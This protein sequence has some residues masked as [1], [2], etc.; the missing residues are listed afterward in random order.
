VASTVLAR[1]R[2]LGNDFWVLPGAIALAF[3]LLAQAFVAIDRRL[4]EGAFRF[5]FDGDA[6]AARGVL[7]TVAGSVITVAGLTFSLTIVVLS[8]VSGQ[9]TPR[10]VPT[11]L[12]DRVTQATA[13]TFI[14][15]FTYCLLVLRSVRDPADGGVSGFVPE[16]SVTTAVGLAVL[17]IALL[18]YF[19]HH[20]GVSIQASSIVNR[21]GRQTLERIREL[22]EEEVE[23]PDEPEGEPG[24]VRAAEPGYV[25][26]VELAALADGLDGCEHVRLRVVPGDFVTGADPL[27]HVWPPGAAEGAEAV[28]RG[29][30]PVAHERDLRQDPL[31]GL[32][33][34]AEIAMKALSPGVNDPSTAESAI[35]YLR[36]GLEEL[37]ARPLPPALVREQVV[38]PLRSFEDYVSGA[39]AQVASYAAADASVATTL[40]DALARIAARARA[41]GHDD[42]VGLLADLAGRAAEQAVKRAGT[43]AE[44]EDIRAA[45]A[46]VG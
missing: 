39:F 7:E 27:A 17:A 40:L 9:F 28:V 22:P 26:H 36:A 37:A 3:A 44:R 46:R 29:S 19:I 6:S 20:L 24:P 30:I 32:R 33:Q 34:L 12:A 13:G 21:I 45:L 23:V 41:T 11:F 5:T 35:G 14:G 2:A 4:G 18:L 31:Y 42:R 25:R 16:L 43:D 8:L 38:A 10:S 1:L 15:V